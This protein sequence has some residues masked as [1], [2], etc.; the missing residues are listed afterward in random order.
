MPFYILKH[1]PIAPG[2]RRIVHEQI[3]IA[4][5]A[6][7]N[8]AV[9][10]TKKVHSLRARCKKMRG[11]LRLARFVMGETYKV[12]DGKFKASARQLAGYRD[13]E[14]VARTIASLG[15]PTVQIHVPGL[16]VPAAVIER[17]GHI[18][19]ACEATVDDWP[20]D[21]D[22]FD[23]IA[24]GFAWTYQKCLDAWDVIPRGQSDEAFHVLRRFTKYHW[25]QV[26]IL[27]RL[28]KKKIRKRRTLL[29]DLQRALGDAHDIVMLLAAPEFQDGGDT[30]LLRRALARKNE[31][32][33]HAMKLCDIVFAQTTEDL[34]A[35]Y[36][37]WWAGSR[38]E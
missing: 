11:L 27:E 26:R 14:V 4:L 29:R 8:D 10:V 12:E 38:G 1:E 36:S 34:V 5:D 13:R 15:G 18:L 32:Y 3:G 7:A 30:P 9:P 24:P 6:L 23:D 37:C 21:I 22:G 2:L 16:L 20:L 31:L 17:A 25:Y 19:Q 33:E 35:D 28:N